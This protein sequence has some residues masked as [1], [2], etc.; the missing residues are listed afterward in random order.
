MQ[1]KQIKVQFIQLDLVINNKK[2][3]TYTKMSTIRWSS[4]TAHLNNNA[5]GCDL[6]LA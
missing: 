5:P 3:E 2:E 1:I 4:I 6:F